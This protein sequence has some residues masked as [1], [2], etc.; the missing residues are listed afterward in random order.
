M[1]NKNYLKKKSTPS[2]ESDGLGGDGVS[3]CWPRATDVALRGQ[4]LGMENTTPRHRP[5][6]CRTGRGRRA[7]GASVPGRVGSSRLRLRGNFL[8]AGRVL[9]NYFSNNRMTLRAVF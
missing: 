7:R 5:S 9:G 3:T 1:E 6:S 2:V 8:Y 4:L